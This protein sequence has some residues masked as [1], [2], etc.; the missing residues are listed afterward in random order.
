MQKYSRHDSQKVRSP[1]EFHISQSDLCYFTVAGNADCGT[2]VM[3][4]GSGQS[5]DLATSE[6]NSGTI[7]L[8]IHTFINKSICYLSGL[9]VFNLDIVVAP[10]LSGT[11]TDSPT[12][13][14]SFVPSHQPS[15]VPSTV[16]SHTPSSDPS[17]A[18]PSAVPSFGPMT[19]TI[20]GF[21]TP[22]PQTFPDITTNSLYRMTVVSYELGGNNINVNT[23]ASPSGF[24]SQRAQTN[25]ET[26]QHY[27]AYFH[28]EEG[29]YLFVSFQINFVVEDHSIT[30]QAVEG[31]FYYSEC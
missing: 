10:P 24:C 11:P 8:T 26:G 18:S 30:A 31:R 28:H 7:V 22:D 14:P 27:V 6:M 3:L 4:W 25:N 9:G 20:T 21:L 1:V 15:A 2:V 5:A 12:V 13:V 23:S 29:Y 16:P 17:V 19:S